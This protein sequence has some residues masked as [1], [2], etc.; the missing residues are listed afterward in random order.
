VALYICWEGELAS[1]LKRVE[2]SVVVKSRGGHGEVKRWRM[3]CWW[4][5]FV[6]V[7][8]SRLG[9]CCCGFVSTDGAG[10]SVCCEF[11]VFREQ[12]WLL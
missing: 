4:S 7:A 6:C 9:F 8:A 10:V 1:G 5:F 3:S 2:T 12:F 11:K